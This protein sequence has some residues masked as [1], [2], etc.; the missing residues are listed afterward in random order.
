MRWS[1]V[2]LLAG[3]GVVMAGCNDDCET[4]ANQ[5]ED[6]YDEC[7]FGLP[8]EIDLDVDVDCNDAL[9]ADYQC[10]ADCADNA[11]CGAL[12]G[13]DTDAEQDYADCRDGCTG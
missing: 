12:D 6:R 10:L 5:L 7:G 4:A 1:V 2:L 9:A 3:A 11:P 13:T 8:G